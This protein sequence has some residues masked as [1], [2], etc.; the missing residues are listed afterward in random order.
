MALDTLRANKLRS[1]LT[2]LGIVIGVMTVITISSV[3]NGLN[4][5][6]ENLVQS[7]GSN[8]LF[9]FRFP[10]FGSRPTTEMLTR[11]QLTYD[12]A[13]AMGEL[14]HVV[15]V[16]PVLQYVD[17]NSPGR[18]GTT[19][20]KANGHSMQS[21]KLE[22][23]TP[24]VKDVN[25]L[26]LAEG[27]FFTDMDQERA[28]NVTV[29]GSDTADELFPGID[30]LGGEVEAGGMLFTVVGVLEK[31]KQ[32]FGGGKN[33]E[34]NKAIFPITTYHKL[35]PES[36]DYWITLKYDDP[37][38]RP[39]VED[40]LTELLRRRRKVLNEAQDN[41]AIFGTDS[42]TRLWNQVTGGLFL[43][44][45]ALSS[46]ALLVGGV[47]V[48]NIMLVSVTERTREIGVRKA[49]GA[50]KR[51]IL[52]QFTLEAMT[53]CAVG[54]VAGV[55]VGSIVSLFLKLLLPTILSSLWIG[56]AFACSCAIGLIFGIYPAWKAANL[57][58]IEALR[59]E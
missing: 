47:G 55:I 44:L 18:V 24:A 20:I 6:V 30:P 46:V 49:I 28:A 3:I 25:G 12:D 27:R 37:K 21:T 48:M 45:F 9:V 5:N 53:L 4:S 11:K 10:V 29:L 2:I 19:A 1:G 22:G 39:L 41:F 8:V 13:M 50:T 54:G 42:L 14:P 43:L 36:L 32:A 34:D 17:N 7:L 23:D 59:Y 38:N 33:P 16:S 58:P 35:H 15:A 40:E 56:T 52:T 31:Q 57:N 26:N 51:T